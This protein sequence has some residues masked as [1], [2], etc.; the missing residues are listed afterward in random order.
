MSQCVIDLGDK[1]PLGEGD[2]QT[3]YQNVCEEKITRTVNINSELKVNGSRCIMEK[4]SPG[5][6]TI[7]IPFVHLCHPLRLVI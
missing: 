4:M 5:S 2:Y 1:C 7:T 3:K 6:C